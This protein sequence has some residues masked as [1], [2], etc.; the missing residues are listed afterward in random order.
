VVERVDGARFARLPTPAIVKLRNGG[1]VVFGGLMANG[2]YRLFDPLSRADRGV[3]LDDLAAEVEPMAI[4]WPA[5]RS[6]PASTRRPS[7]SSGSCRR[8]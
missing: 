2:V 6:A 7:D 4:L 8:S 1:F 5:R 3:S